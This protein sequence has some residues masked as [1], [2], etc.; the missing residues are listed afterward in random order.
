M[1]VVAVSFFSGAVFVVFVVYSGT[2]QNPTKHVDIE[3][4]ACYHWVRL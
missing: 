4:L 2:D 1:I 3:G